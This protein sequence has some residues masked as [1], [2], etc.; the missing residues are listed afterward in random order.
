MDCILSTMI[1]KYIYLLCSIIY[2]TL[3]TKTTLF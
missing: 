3:T 1:Q 2:L